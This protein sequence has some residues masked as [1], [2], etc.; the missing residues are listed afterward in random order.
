MLQTLAGP[1]DFVFFYAG[2]KDYEAY[3][4][5]FLPKIR[6]GGLIAAFNISRQSPEAAA[7]VRSITGNPLLKTDLVAITPAGLSVSQKL[8][9]K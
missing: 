5:T 6:P 1:F 7:F 3:L 2:L 8:P 9:A 4:K